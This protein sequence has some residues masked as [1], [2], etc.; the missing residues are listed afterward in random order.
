MAQ[1]L[2]QI[3]VQQFVL[4][5]HGRPRPRTDKDGLP[6]GGRQIRSPYDL[7]TRF[8]L[9]GNT[10]WSGYLLHVTETCDDQGPNVITDAATT[11][12]TRDTAALPGIHDRLARRAL[13]PGEHFADGGYLSVALLEQAQREHG[14][15][16][17]GPVKASGGWQHR[18]H[19]GFARDDFTIDFDHR[20][21]TCPRGQTS[22]A[23]VQ[24]PSHTP[25]ISA[26]FHPRQCDPCP[27]RASCTRGPTARVVYFLPRHLHELPAQNRA[28][29]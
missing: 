1:A 15:T 5:R 10:R 12:P 11:T 17:V 18:E 26:R 20:Q 25:Y 4:D 13:L 3:L 24:A 7:D 29:Q 2:R 16:L 21:V 14:L 23:W 22:T 27:I 19:T 8:A 9:R 28:D 6:P